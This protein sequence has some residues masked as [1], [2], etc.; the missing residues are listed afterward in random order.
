MIIIGMVLL[1]GSFVGRSSLILQRRQ[2]DI[3]LIGL[4]HVLAIQRLPCP[5]VRPL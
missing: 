1:M 4:V 5:S 2:G 3:L